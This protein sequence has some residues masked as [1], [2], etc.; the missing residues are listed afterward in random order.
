MAGWEALRD[1][2]AAPDAAARAW[3]AGGG[4]VAGYLANTAPRELMA[5]AG[6]FPLQLS[7]VAGEPTP[8]ADRYMEDLFDPMVRSVFQRL[9]AGHYDFLDVLVLPRT[10]DS[11]QRLYYYLSEMDRVGAARLPEV[12]LLD[13]LHTPWSSSAAYNLARMGELRAALERLGGKPVADAALSAEIKAANSRRA[14]LR[15]LAEARRTRPPSRGAEQALHAFSAYHHMAG[16]DFDAAI[17]AALQAPPEAFPGAPRDGPRLV[18][19]GSPL[20]NPALHR[21]VESLGAVVVGDHHP[22]GELMIGTDVA[23]AGDPMAA[24]TEHYHR[25]VAS[26]RTFPSRPGELVDFARAA[27]AD[28]VVFYFLAEEEA[29][30]WEYP[31]QKRALEAAGIATLAFTMQPYRLDAEPLSGPLTAFIDGLRSARHG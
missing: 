31:G 3:K 5:A 10:S 14:S 29:L 19:S 15:R 21:L 16:A 6:F 26:S 23:E 9:L 2:Y 25:G 30:T 27:G 28:G 11:V 12:R 20:D 18:L 4:R 22:C 8:L 7:G 24:L 1:V 13:L 17:A